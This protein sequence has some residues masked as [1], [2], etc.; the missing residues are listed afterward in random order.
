MN[1]ETTKRAAALATWIVIQ[2]VER[3]PDY[4]DDLNRAKD[5]EACLD[6]GLAYAEQERYVDA[7]KVM[8]NF[9]GMVLAHAP[10]IINDDCELMEGLGVL[11][12]M[13]DDYPGV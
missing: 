12:Q 9:L 11:A 7:L 1:V 13:D 3:N 10:N 8:K 5:S 6:Q 4:F 2:I